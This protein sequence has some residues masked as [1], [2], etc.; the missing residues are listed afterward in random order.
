MADLRQRGDP[1]IVL[2]V[3]SF[4][5]ADWQTIGGLAVSAVALAA[6]LFALRGGPA[7]LAHTVPA[8][9][10]EDRRQFDEIVEACL[11]DLA[12]RDGGRP[13]P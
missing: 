4:S 2:A 5:A 7:P 13:Y 6:G 8:P 3:E 10:D 11:A 9:V 12:R 1:R